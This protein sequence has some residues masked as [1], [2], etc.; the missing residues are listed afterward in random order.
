M[1]VDR[2]VVRV[3]AGSGGS[4]TSSFR[5]ERFIPLGGPDGGGQVCTKRS[6]A[7]AGVAVDQEVDLVGEEVAM[8]HDVLW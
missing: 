1:F 5:R 8:V 4:G 3:E 7:E 6:D 2:V